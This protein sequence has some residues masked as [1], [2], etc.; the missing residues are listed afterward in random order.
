MQQQS[1]LGRH[2]W[3]IGYLAYHRLVYRHHRRVVARQTN[4]S[5]GVLGWFFAGAIVCFFL[6]G[7]I[8]VS[9]GTAL[10]AT[11]W[12]AMAIVIAV[13]LKGMYSAWR[14]E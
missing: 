13:T 5:G 8:T 7:W 2:K 6:W 1:P 3:L 4:D 10:A 9:Q 14:G 11:G 12:I